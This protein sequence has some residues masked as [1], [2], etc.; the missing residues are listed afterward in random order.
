MPTIELVVTDLDGTLWDSDE[1][2]HRRTLSALHTLEER[3]VPLL[4]ATGRRPRSAAAGLA[5]ESLAPPAVFLDGALGRDAPDGRV[6]HEAA[7][8]PDDAARVLDAFESCGLSPCVYVERG[9]TDV[10]VGDSPSTHPRHLAHLHPWSQQADLRRAVATERIFAFGVVGADTR[11]VTG[12]GVNGSGHAVVVADRFFGGSS[13][14]VRPRGTS[15]WSGVQAF[16]AQRGIDPG[17]VLAVG[18]GENDIELLT[19]AQVSC[20]VSDGCDAALAVA[21]HVID[22]AAVGGWSQILRLL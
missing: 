7:F 10:L 22:P 12:L 16:C 20:V 9:D 5:R 6:F 11:A 15:K 17:R 8:R 18:D 4:V 2:I 13:V 1:R 19:G 14:M 3:G 21:D